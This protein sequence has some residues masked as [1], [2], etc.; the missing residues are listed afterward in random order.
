MDEPINNDPVTNA[1][2]RLTK[3]KTVKEVLED[4]EELKKKDKRWYLMMPRQQGRSAIRNIFD[5]K[6]PSDDDLGRPS[7][8]P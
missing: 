8:R 4:F 6:E 5:K 1:E 2:M 7:N 3:W